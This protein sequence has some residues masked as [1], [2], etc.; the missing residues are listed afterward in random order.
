M[1]DEIVADLAR[2]LKPSGNTSQSVKQIRK[3]AQRLHRLEEST[4]KD[5]IT[6]TCR[7]LGLPETVAARALAFADIR[8]RRLGHPSS[9]QTSAD[10]GIEPE[11]A[12]ELALAFYAADV[13]SRVVG[14]GR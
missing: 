14:S 5:R 11:E 8:G 10:F 13:R 1:Q 9:N 2:R 4:L 3:A 12:E 6:L 7:R